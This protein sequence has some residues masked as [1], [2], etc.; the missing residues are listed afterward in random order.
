MSSSD[1]VICPVLA[2][3]S[4]VPCEVDTQSTTA[5]P[6]QEN[7]S[8][9]QEDGLGWDLQRRLDKTTHYFDR[10]NRLRE[11]NH[12]LS[13]ELSVTKQER[14]LAQA[15]LRSLE[16]SS[17][18]QAE[19]LW[20]QI[21][22]LR[23][24]RDL[25]QTFQ[26]PAWESDERFPEL[27]LQIP[28][29]KR[30]R[31]LAQVSLQSLQEVT[32][33]HAE[34]EAPVSEL[35]Q[36]H[37]L[38][39]A[40]S[41]SVQESIEKQAEE[42]KL[43]ISEL[44]KERDLAR[45]SLRSL[46]ESSQRHAQLEVQVS[47]LKQER[48]LAHVALQSSWESLD[49]YSDLKLKIWDLEEQRSHA[50]ASLRALRASTEG[51]A[52]IKIQAAQ[53][54]EDKAILQQAVNGVYDFCKGI[55][56]GKG[57]MQGG[58]AFR[59]DIPPAPSSISSGPGQ[60]QHGVPL[61]TGPTLYLSRPLLPSGQPSSTSFVHPVGLQGSE[62]A[63]ERESQL[64]KQGTQFSGPWFDDWSERTYQ[65]KESIG[66]PNY[67]QTVPVRIENPISSTRPQLNPSMNMG[68]GF[69]NAREPESLPDTSYNN[70]NKRTASGFPRSVTRKSRSSLLT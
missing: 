49:R 48:N 22:E 13:S 4:V 25:A 27:G 56:L 63:R 60:E 21:I 69:V 36:E 44:E 16:E 8:S 37:D 2:C 39:Q 31:D 64:K 40:S 43:R 45:A 20:L 10:I 24:E 33:R 58:L 12:H 67:H 7:G 38:A 23:Q 14:D 18:S 41:P 54:K 55:L 26:Q 47:E 29:V 46:Q 61:S 59:G 70:K 66:G 17:K 9:I 3:S 11:E 5:G 19:E 32:E 57:L 42:S 15:S 53:L 52:E 1:D 51:H 50:E 35:K 30:E 6:Q 28:E 65:W 62:L 34:L 68:N